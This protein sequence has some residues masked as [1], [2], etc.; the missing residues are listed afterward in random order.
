MAIAGLWLALVGLTGAAAPAS[1][2]ARRDLYGD[3]LPPM[4]AGRLGTARLRHG[5]WEGQD[6]IELA[7][8]PD[9]KRLASLLRGG[10]MITAWDA[11]TGRLLRTVTP[12]DADGLA[13][14]AIAFLSDSETVAALCSRYD[15][16][17][18]RHRQELLAWRLPTGEQVS[19]VA[20]LAGPWALAPDGKRFAAGCEDKPGA[21]GIY[22]LDGKRQ[23]VLSSLQPAAGS[24][25]VSPA[26]YRLAWSHDGATLA[27]A[28][29]SGLMLWD[30]AT[31]KGRRLGAERWFG[32]NTGGASGA[33]LSPDGKLLALI[34]GGAE[35]AVVRADTGEVTQRLKGHS[36]TVSGVRFSPDGRRLASWGRFEDA[37]VILWDVTAGKPAFTYRRHPA[38]HSGEVTDVAF[39][40]GGRA[41]A[42]VGG[43]SRIHVWDANDGRPLLDAGAPAAGIEHLLWTG[44]GREVVLACRDGDIHV[45][46]AA[47]CR[48]RLV[49]R[50]EP[51]PAAG[52]RGRP[53]G[54]WLD[55]QRLWAALGCSLSRWDLRSGRLELSAAPAKPQY[56]LSAAFDPPS[57]WF[58]AAGG[59]A[60]HF[61]DI[62]GATMRLVDTLSLGGVEVRFLD[63]ERIA[64]LVGSRSG[65][66]SRLQVVGI[67]RERRL[68]AKPQLTIHLDRFPCEHTA[69]SADCGIVY[70][71]GRRQA[72]A[73][74]VNRREWLY[75]VGQPGTGGAPD[76]AGD[77]TAI[78]VSPDGVLLAL[79]RSSGRIDLLE[80]PTGREVLVLRGHL[81]AVNALAFSPDGRRLASG[82]EDCTALLWSLPVGDRAA[83][84]TAERAAALW[85]DL[86]GS[87]A[88]EAHKAV[89]T[90]AAQPTPAMA[91]L[92]QRLLPVPVP[93]VPHLEKLIAALGAAKFAERQAAAAELD[94]LTDDAL[95]AL[96]A[97]LQRRDLDV[98]PRARIEQAVRR[99]EGIRQAAPPTAEEMRAIRAVSVLERIGSP[100][101]VQLLER[102]AAGR[103]DSRQTRAAAQALQRLRRRPATSRPAGN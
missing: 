52:P 36:R 7:V 54:L 37:V 71:A 98:E 5:G 18:N 93:D 15:R 102:L 32:K 101:A 42:S 31:G 19:S 56:T 46:D 91:M 41:V 6:V 70:A 4:A 85:D 35:I 92:K 23:K 57:G 20:G 83:D 13:L 72:G 39:L 38:Q 99:L 60:M 58:V 67:H 78:A 63:G 64:C 14:R 66:T 9:G 95:P 94:R 3:P 11:G 59:T 80:A 84:L 62:S 73:Y 45:Y 96:R 44:D 87:D 10:K 65:G 24:R 17:A 43:G 33:A 2:P 55:G 8:S 103:S 1:A 77:Y 49:L 26:L 82:G 69:I 97:A 29:R 21:V 86:A 61:H 100:E 53:L 50:D 79:G 25:Q 51:R 16:A 89:L 81:G 74:D 68:E 76:D 48:R 88:A 30:V 34:D 75:V 90:L 28:G 12:A 47:S 22:A 27:A 40:R